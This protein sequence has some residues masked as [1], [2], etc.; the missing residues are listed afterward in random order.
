MTSADP[1]TA[2]RRRRSPASWALIA[3]VILPINF[4]VWMLAMT[5]GRRHETVALLLLTLFTVLA[6]LS[7]MFWRRG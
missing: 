2:P 4:G 3:L 7:P 1:T 5:A 6:V